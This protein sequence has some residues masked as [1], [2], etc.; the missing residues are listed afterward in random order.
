M[1]TTQIQC[2]QLIKKL[3][4]D[5]FFKYEFSKRK[6]LEINHLRKIG[7]RGNA[8]DGSPSHLASSTKLWT[9]PQFWTAFKETSNFLLIN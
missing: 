1:R 8:F 5:P 9:H 4:T 7:F 3:T 6:A 2:I